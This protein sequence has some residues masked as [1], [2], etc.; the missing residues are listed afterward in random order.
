MDKISQ[1]FAKITPEDFYRDTSAI[2]QRVLDEPLT[3]EELF[4]QFVD[5][6][7]V[8]GMQRVFDDHNLGAFAVLASAEQQRIFLAD[9]DETPDQWA[10]RL[11]REAEQIDAGWLFVG[12]VAAARHYTG[13]V[14]PKP[15]ERTVEA[16]EDAL[17]V[18]G[19][20]LSLCWSAFRSED[21]G[22][23]ALAGMVAINPDGTPGERTDGLVSDVDPNP[24]ALILRSRA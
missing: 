20:T 11:R 9:D 14:N 22:A 21:D 4:Q 7:I 16:I 10:A 17:D 12:L 15:I 2:H 24:F 1:A 8:L 13:A 3:G 23:S 5:E 18:G 19:L 6:L